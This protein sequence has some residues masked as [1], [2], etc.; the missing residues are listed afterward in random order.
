MRFGKLKQNRCSD[1]VVVVD[2]KPPS[3]V[4]IVVDFFPVGWGFCGELDREAQLS[5]ENR[6]PFAA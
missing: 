4:G 1:A 3:L 6:S 5:D 2:E